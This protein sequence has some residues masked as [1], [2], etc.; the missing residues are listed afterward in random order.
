MALFQQSGGTGN[1]RLNEARKLIEIIEAGDSE[2]LSGW[3]VN[4]VESVSDQ[5]ER[6][7]EISA[8]QI[9]KLRDIKDKIL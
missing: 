2:K 4:F 5:V 7:R 3:E 1:D 8:K 9:F 6:G